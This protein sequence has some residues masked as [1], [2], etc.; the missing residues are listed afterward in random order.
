MKRTGPVK[1]RV[2]FK[3]KTRRRHIDLLLTAVETA[4]GTVAEDCCIQRMLVQ[5]LPLL[6][7]MRMDATLT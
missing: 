2:N 3:E 7:T 6:V 1:Y 5:T 4:E